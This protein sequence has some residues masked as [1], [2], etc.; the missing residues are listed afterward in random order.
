MGFN[1]ID[2]FLTPERIDE[3]EKSD[4]LFIEADQMWDG[5]GIEEEK[6]QELYSSLSENEYTSAI[7][8]VKG[9][10]YELDLTGF[11]DSDYRVSPEGEVEPVDPAT[12]I[13]NEIEAFYRETY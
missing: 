2:R 1:S 8:L 10:P 13:I 4:K 3:S 11:D 6:R 9:D 7:V 12:D 5:M